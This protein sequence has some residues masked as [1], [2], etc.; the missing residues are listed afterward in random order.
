MADSSFRSNHLGIG[1]D[2]SQI[3]SLS[4]T[5][6][7]HAE[8]P[9]LSM[10]EPMTGVPRWFVQEAWTGGSRFGRGL[11]QTRMWREDGMQIAS[12]IQDGMMRLKEDEGKGKV[13]F[14]PEQMAQ[15]LEAKL[16]A[17]RRQGKL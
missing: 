6:I 1:N 14:S 3:A 4:H 2:Y 16:K 11:H 5:V 13:G 17:D 7:M 15:Q 10:V 9:E 8:P 12:T